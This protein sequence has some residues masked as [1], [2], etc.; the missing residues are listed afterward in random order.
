MKISPSLLEAAPTMLLIRVRS[1]F[2]LSGTIVEQLELTSGA[3]PQ[4]YAMP[5]MDCSF[6]S[7]SSRRPKAWSPGLGAFASNCAFCSLA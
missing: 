3:P 7:S 1:Y 6:S 2:F 4:P 5:A